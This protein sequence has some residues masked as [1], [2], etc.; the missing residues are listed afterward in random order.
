MMHLL[1]SRDLVR[2]G[3]RILHFAPE[4][5][6]GQR[7]MEIVGPENYEAYDLFP[8]IYHESL[9]VKEFDLTQASRLR[10]EAYDLIL[11]AHVLEHIPCYIAA[12]LWHLQRA[13]TATG[14]HLFCMPVLPGR[15][16]SDFNPITEQDRLRRFG[17]KD[18]V[19][20]FGVEDMEMTLGQVFDLNAQNSGIKLDPAI[21]AAHNID[22]AEI[23]RTVFLMRKDDLLL[24]EKRMAV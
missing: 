2:P 10:T 16:E 6:I 5:G 1:E 24:S 9:N 13:L 12:V 20:R 4:Q 23:E 19:R 14:A 21:V 11:H 7:L 18:H 8:G 15:H 17:Q 22:A 3:M